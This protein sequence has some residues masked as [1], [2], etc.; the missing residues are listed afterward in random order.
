MDLAVG[1]SARDA[2]RVS[3]GAIRLRLL[4]LVLVESAMLAFRAASNRGQTD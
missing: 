2:L 1:T 3:I 4:Q